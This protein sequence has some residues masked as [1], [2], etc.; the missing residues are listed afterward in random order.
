MRVARTLTLF[1]LAMGFFAAGVALAGSTG[2][3]AWA[4]A[5]GA[6]VLA[7]S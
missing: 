4:M 2:P 6:L 5:A 3:I 7:I 1:L